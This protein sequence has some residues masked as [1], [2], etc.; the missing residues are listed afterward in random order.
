MGVYPK[1]GIVGS[2]G[3]F[4]FN[5]LRDVCLLLIADPSHHVFLMPPV[6]WLQDS[7]QDEHRALHWEGTSN[8]GKVGF[9]HTCPEAEEWLPLTIY[10]P[11][12]A[13]LFKGHDILCESPC[14][15]REN[16]M[17][18]PK[19]LIQRRGSCL[20]GRVLL[21]VVHLQVPVYEVALS[22]TDHF[23][24]RKTE[25]YFQQNSQTR[26]GRWWILS[27]L[28]RTGV[29]CLPTKTQARR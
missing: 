13:A 25:D 9:G 14:F 19:L 7:A 6:L 20:C 5:F 24:T 4:E 12:D 23:H 11:I 21:K 3:N 29:S 28:V 26:V 27:S 1:S 10:L 2:H 16:V 17:D 8:A 18:L 15:I 22:K